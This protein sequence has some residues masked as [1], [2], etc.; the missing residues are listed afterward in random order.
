[1]GL[2]A[3]Y[4]LRLI[5]AVWVTFNF[6]FSATPNIKN[7][8][9][10][11]LLEYRGFAKTSLGQPADGA[12]YQV[13]ATKI[14]PDIT[15][16]ISPDTGGLYSIDA[17][18]IGQFN[19]GDTIIAH[20]Y[21]GYRPQDSSN[22]VHVVTPEDTL[23]LWQY[24]PQ[25]YCDSSLVPN[26]AYAI[27]IRNVFSPVNTRKFVEFYL[28]KDPYNRDT[29]FGPQYNSADTFHFNLEHLP[30]PAND[31]DTVYM[32]IGLFNIVGNDTIFNDTIYLDT[33]A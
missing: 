19:V 11:G 31:G 14:P 7:G 21:N 12:I 16:T 26:R 33:F 24:L 9:Q 23:E 27:S 18:E 30:Q 2:R 5:F 22:T 20:L 6:V 28:R 13:R 17:S 10:A 32:H 3:L 29:V 4:L 1:M 15:R 8:P 25:I